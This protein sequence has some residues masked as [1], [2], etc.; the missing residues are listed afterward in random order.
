MI[1]LEIIGAIA[2]LAW[3]YLLLA[4]GFFWLARERSST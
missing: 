3:L 1:A 2:V 4:R